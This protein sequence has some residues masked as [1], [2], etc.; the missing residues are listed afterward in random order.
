MQSKVTNSTAVLK[1]NPLA[2]EGKYVEVLSS[3]EISPDSVKLICHTHKVDAPYCHHATDLDKLQYSM[4]RLTDD[5]T[6]FP[7]IFFS[8]KMCKE[9]SSCYWDTH[10]NEL[11][12][13]D[14]S[15]V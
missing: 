9:D 7:V 14:K 13:I 12:I 2:L 4:V 8:H 5:G 11:V 3:K 6:V 15:I 1:L 10:V